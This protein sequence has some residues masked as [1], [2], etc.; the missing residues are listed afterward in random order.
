MVQIRSVGVIGAGQMGTGIAHVVALG[1][2]DV[3]LHDVSR[4]RIEAGLKAIERNLSR[5][6]VRGIID[7]PA[8]DAAIARIDA[9]LRHVMQ[10]HVVAAE[11]HHM[12]DARTHLARA[13]DADRPNVN[14]SVCL[15]WRRRFGQKPGP[16]KL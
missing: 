10:Q 16:R 12:G 7:Q 5:Q 1:G 3:L 14:H 11:R 6:V 9:I 8:M 15:R 13:D 2:Y 4:D